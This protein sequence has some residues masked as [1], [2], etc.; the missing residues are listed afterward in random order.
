M[1]IHNGKIGNVE[2]T[3]KGVYISRGQYIEQKSMVQIAMWV[4]LAPFIA[5]Y[6]WAIFGTVSSMPV[7]MGGTVILLLL[8]YFCGWI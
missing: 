6:L 2:I 8:I 4:M 7:T 1:K 3:D 5:L